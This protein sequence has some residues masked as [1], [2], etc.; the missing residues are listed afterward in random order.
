MDKVG[1]QFARRGTTM[2]KNNLRIHELDSNAIERARF[3][4]E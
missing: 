4:E 1:E 2:T 3:S